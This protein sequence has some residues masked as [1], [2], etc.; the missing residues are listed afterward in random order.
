MP[1]SSILSRWKAGKSRQHVEQPEQLRDHKRAGLAPEVIRQHNE[2]FA[3]FGG[4]EAIQV[5]S[6]KR[7]QSVGAFNVW[8]DSSAG[9]K[10]IEKHPLKAKKE[11]DGS[12]IVW[13][14]LNANDD[15]DEDEPLVSR[16]GLTIRRKSTRAG[17]VPVYM[18]LQERSEWLAEHKD[19]KVKDY[20]KSRE[21]KP[22][23]AYTIISQ[24]LSGT[25][26]KVKAQVREGSMMSHVQEVY[27]PLKD[28]ALQF[29][30]RTDVARG[31]QRDEKFDKQLI[32]SPEFKLIVLSMFTRLNPAS[33][34]SQ[35]T[36]G[37]PVEVDTRNAGEL[38]RKIV[39]NPAAYVAT[40]VTKLKEWDVPEE[41][42]LAE[43]GLLEAEEGEAVEEAPAPA[44]QARRALP[45]PAA[46]VETG[47]T[48]TLVPAEDDDQGIQDIE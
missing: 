37:R 11:E 45:A 34:A 41:L 9:R 46:K 44:R 31:V 47:Q 26:Q 5:Q 18:S 32:S 6:A 10:A 1:R 42:A 30:Y 14:D 29:I 33:V 28:K 15:W 39:R 36:G 3:Q 35:W 43:I 38:A 7:F 2:Q 13:I 8:K 17:A 20:K 16:N 19:L 48:L 25:W 40:M 23:S 21:V 27:G 22:K 4:A 24:A 12:V